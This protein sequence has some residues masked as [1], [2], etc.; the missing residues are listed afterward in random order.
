MCVVLAPR[1]QENVKIPLAREPSHSKCRLTS[2]HGYAI[3]LITESILDYIPKLVFDAP[4]WKYSLLSRSG[5][6][7]SN[8]TR[9]VLCLFMP[10]AV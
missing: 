8:R 1:V 5:S 4:N 2:V 3:K 10:L 9:N 7:I 6:E